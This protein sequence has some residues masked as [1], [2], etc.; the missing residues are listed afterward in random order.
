MRM[1]RAVVLLL[2]LG[3]LFPVASTA[4]PSGV[5]TWWGN[6]GEAKKEKQRTEIYSSFNNY[7]ED[8]EVYRKVNPYLSPT[9]LAHE[10]LSLRSRTKGVDP[11]GVVLFLG[12][13]QRQDYGEKAEVSKEIMKVVDRTEGT[14]QT[15]FIGGGHRGGTGFLFDHLPQGNVEDGDFTFRTNRFVG[16]SGSGWVDY[17]TN[18]FGQNYTEVEPSSEVSRALDYL[19]ISPSYGNFEESLRSSPGGI[20]YRVQLFFELLS[21]DPTLKASVIV[22]EGN[23]E[24]FREVLQLLT[25]S[26]SRLPDELTIYSMQGLKP[27]EEGYNGV[28]RAATAT[29]LVLRDRIIDLGLDKSVSIEPFGGSEPIEWV[30]MTQE[31]VEKEG[32][33]GRTILRLARRAK[34]LHLGHVERPSIQVDGWV[35]KD[36]GYRLVRTNN[37]TLQEY[38]LV[39]GILK[40]VRIADQELEFAKSREWARFQVDRG[41]KL[42]HGMLKQGVEANSA[43]FAQMRTNIL[44]VRESY[45]DIVDPKHLRFLEN[46][47]KGRR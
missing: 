21:M 40:A 7:R 44:A 46:L 17:G 35:A 22:A 11:Q 39:E 32:G 41:L 33:G 37:P 19:L 4:E 3:F 6:I 12:Y 31:S 45:R 13:D 28:F 34:Y 1:S 42:E 8:E 9:K 20:S 25:E 16:V 29:H 18:H 26:V 36:M 15:I 23:Q 24:A 38:A 10:L 5:R 27:R 30:P 2:G 43:K 47:G 14:K